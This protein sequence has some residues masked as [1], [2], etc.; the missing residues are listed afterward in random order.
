MP[1]AGGRQCA[2]KTAPFHAR[3]EV[4]RRGDAPGGRCRPRPPCVMIASLITSIPNGIPMRRHRWHHGL[5]CCAAALLPLGTVAYAQT[6]ANGNP[7]EEIIVTAT[8]IE[9][10]LARTPASVS[11]VGEDDIQLGR[12]QL[13]LD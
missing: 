13:A 9:R 1:G 3:D 12:Q 11:V 5:T 8:M 2:R 7:L 10:T 4:L 6:P